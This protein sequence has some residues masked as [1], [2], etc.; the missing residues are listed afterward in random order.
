MK[1]LAMLVAGLMCSTLW[2]STIPEK[3]ETNAFVA[4]STNTFVFYWAKPV[5][6]KIRVKKSKDKVCIEGGGLKIEGRDGKM[7]FNHSINNSHGDFILDKPDYSKTKVTFYHN[8]TALKVYFPK[9]L[10]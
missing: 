8:R 10:L 9:K 4:G 5:Q 3:I 1:M 7:F 6:E 2:H